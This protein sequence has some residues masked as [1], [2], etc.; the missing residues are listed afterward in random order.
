MRPA[1]TGV[2][3]HGEELAV[4]E[5]K[6]L[7]FKILERNFR[8]G[9]GEI[10]VIAVEKGVLVFIEVK[11]R[12]SGRFGTPFDAVHPGKQKKIASAARAYLAQKRL[13]EV[14]ARFDVAGVD[15]DATPPV[16]T[17]LRD[18]FVLPR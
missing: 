8:G 7:G 1:T 4:A 6:R 11:A 15:L 17:L 3:A 13:G 2:G 16:V 18:A 5:L 9:G 10:D 14:G 12:E